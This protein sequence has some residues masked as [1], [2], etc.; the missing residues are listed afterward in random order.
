MQAGLGHSLSGWLG[1]GLAQHRD[2]SRL[3]VPCSPGGGGESI[4]LL[5]SESDWAQMSLF[6]SHTANLS[7]N[8]FILKNSCL[9]SLFIWKDLFISFGYFLTVSHDNCSLNHSHF[10]FCESSLLFHF[11]AFPSCYSMCML[12]YYYYKL[13]IATKQAVESTGLREV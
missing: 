10:A 2:V 3:E 13:G 1:M 7:F 5:S 8:R 6:L 11:D 9:K 12:A 4:C